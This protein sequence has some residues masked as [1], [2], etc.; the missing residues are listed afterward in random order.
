MNIKSDENRK[1]ARI[2]F[3]IE[4]WKWEK[5]KK[6]YGNLS[7]LIRKYLDTLLE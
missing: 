5:L 3:R 4:R 1:D 2:W 7:D 6:K